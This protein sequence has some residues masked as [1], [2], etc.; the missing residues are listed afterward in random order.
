VRIFKWVVGRHLPVNAK[1]DGAVWYGFV[2]VS[3]QS[4]HEVFSGIRDAVIE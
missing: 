2:S 3:E 1:M 4:V